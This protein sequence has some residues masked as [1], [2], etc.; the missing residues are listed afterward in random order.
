MNKKMFSFARTR[1]GRIVCGLATAIAMAGMIMSGSFSTLHAKAAGNGFYVDGTTIRD[2]N[3]NAFIMRGI[4]VA[5]AW[6][7]SYTE[8]SLKAIAATGANTVRIV[9]SDG[10]VYTKTS[11]SELS[12][13]I[14]MCKANNLVCILEVHDA[15]GSDSVSDLNKAV[16]YWIENK[17]ILEGNEKYVIVN[18]ANEWYGTWNKSNWASGNESAIRSIRNAG[19]TNLLMVDCAG[20]GQYPDSIKD[21]GSAVHSADSTGNTVFSIHMYEYAGGN[22]STVKTNIDNAL[23]TGV[24]VVIGEFG[25]RH[26]NGDVDEDTI[27]SYCNTKSVGYLGWSWKGNSSDLSYLDIA[28]DWDGSS[29]SSWG[30]S[31]INGSCGIRKTAKTC[32]VYTGS[33]AGSSSSSGA[34]S[35]ASPY[36]SLFYGNSYAGNWGQAVSVT[37]SKDGGSFDA[38]SIT[39]GGHFYVEYS[40]T[41]GDVELILQSWSGGSSWGKV[42]ISET[43]SANGHYY[44]K[45]SYDNCVSAF[46]SS[47]FSGKLDKIHIGAKSSG[48]TVYSVCYTQ[49]N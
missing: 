17:D 41:E 40:G 12:N 31:L 7:T 20:W 45:F 21:Y 1:A 42:S 25:A 13:I 46:G 16:N 15:T 43:G 34:T 44:A 32:S 49:G 28:N 8:K 35:S 10:A 11:S 6:Y 18:I 9:V 30:E 23:G 39:S 2:A 14:S 29:L 36:V 26:K 38:S 48:I 47:D 5:H 22:A 37:T 33:S 19:I 3:G 4:N 24:P 27:M